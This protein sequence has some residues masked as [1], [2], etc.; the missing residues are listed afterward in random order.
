MS[1]R[2]ACHAEIPRDESEGLALYGE[3][4]PVS[5]LLVGAFPGSPT[6]PRVV[7]AEGPGA[8]ERLETLLGEISSADRAS[9][10]AAVIQ[11]GGS[12]DPW[13]A[14]PVE[15]ALTR[16]RT[17]WL[18]EMLNTDAMRHDLQPIV[19]ADSLAVHGY[20]ALVRS[21]PPMEAHNPGE[22]IE[23]ARAHDALLRF[24]QSSRRLAITG[25]FPKL[26]G[27]ERLFVNFLP[28]TVYDPSVCL[29]TT[30]NAAR[31][32]GAD[33]SRIVFEVVES[34]M[35]PNVE[36][37]CAIL[38]AYREEGA[39]VGLDD[40]GAGNASLVYIDHIKP[41]YIKLDR[42]LMSQAARD[43][44]L[45]MM[46][47]IVR[48][49]QRQGIRV[50]VEGIESEQELDIARWLGADFVQGFHTGRPSAEPVRES[51]GRRAA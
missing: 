51:A 32:V 19:E 6:H 25:C 1:H 37:L 17:P 43:R 36:L 9:I 21:A 22:I 30:F 2:C 38:D 41:D 5:E 8:I 24:D 16:L 23:A 50:I 49:A 3:T 7:L 35:F 15:R 27:D 18:P 26:E 48:H 33:F 29:R 20:E 4:A 42:E 46:S 31:E 11:P 13:T 47:G 40:L 34:E 45:T 10:R 44:E 14:G 28:M 39:S 12:F